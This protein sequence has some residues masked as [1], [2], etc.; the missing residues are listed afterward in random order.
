MWWNRATPTWRA[1]SSMRLGPEHVG[2]EEQ[3]RVR[4][5]P[6]EL[7]DSAAKWTIVSISCSAQRLLG[8]R[9]EVA[10]VPLD[11]D[12]PVLDVGQVGSVAG[13]GEHVVDDDVVVGVLFDPVADEVRP[14]ETGTSG[15]EKAHRAAML[16]Q[17]RV[18]PCPVAAG[19][20][21][22]AWHHV[23]GA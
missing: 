4:G 16:A 15:H 3:A 18:A 9:V 23:A 20:E 19:P 6:G 5:W 14:D 21:A 10:D 17:A 2:P 12:D 8:H 13:V 11:E 7:C 1:A 22:A